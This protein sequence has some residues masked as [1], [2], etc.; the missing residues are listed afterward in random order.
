MATRGARR[1]LSVLGAIVPLVVACVTTPPRPPEQLRA[2]AATAERV[3][4]ALDQDPNFFFRHVDVDVESGV[5]CL[6]GYVWSTEAL[7][8]AQDI[9]R[10][11]PGVVGVK[12]QMELEREAMRGGSDGSQR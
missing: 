10:A 4:A 5:V 6:S 9:A 7:F 8:R 2:D 11:V 12:D 3:Y 1:C